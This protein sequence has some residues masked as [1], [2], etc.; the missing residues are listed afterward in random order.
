MRGHF[1]GVRSLALLL[2]ADLFHPVH[3]LPSSCSCM[4]M[5]VMAV[6]GAPPCQ[7]I[8]IKKLR[9]DKLVLVGGAGWRFYFSKRTLTCVNSPPAPRCTLSMLIL[10]NPASSA[11][12]PVLV[13]CAASRIA[14]SSPSPLPLEILNCSLKS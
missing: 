5:C 13:F 7:C 11:H 2:V 10:R 14:A 3:D 4:A 12:S 9:A 6:I 1:E 8:A